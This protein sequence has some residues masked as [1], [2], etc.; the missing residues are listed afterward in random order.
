MIGV[1]E[2][3]LRRNAPRMP[4][5][6]NTGVKFV[7][8]RAENASDNNDTL[9]LRI[10]FADEHGREHVE[11]FFP[12]DKDKVKERNEKYPRKKR[13]SD[14][15]MS[16]DEQFNVE[17]DEV[18]NKVAH[19]AGAVMEPESVLAMKGKTFKELFKK[20]ADIFEKKGN[21]E[22]PLRL[23]VV[24]RYESKYTELPKYPPFIEP[25]AVNPTG[26][27]ITSRDNMTPPGGSPVQADINDGTEVSEDDVNW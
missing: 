4:V 6:I 11:T 20:M 14:E 7:E 3:H 24:Y 8:A 10:V 13:N 19:I 21:K 25:Q 12:V 26:L 23:K 17:C 2:N 18:V 9:V 22:V 16:A 1:N 27:E 15:P 5:G